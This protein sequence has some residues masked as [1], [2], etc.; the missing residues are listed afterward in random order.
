[1][2]TL[3]W[4]GIKT[5]DRYFNNYVQKNNETSNNQVQ[6]KGSNHPTVDFWS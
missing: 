6:F 5:E 3:S 4:V 1:M 2:E